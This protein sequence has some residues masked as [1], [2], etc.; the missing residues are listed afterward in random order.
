MK[1][2]SE[3][4]ERA[5]I[6]FSMYFGYKQNPMPLIDIGKKMNCSRTRAGILSKKAFRYLIHPKYRER[7]WEE[8]GYKPDEK[9]G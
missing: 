9:S 6:A 1:Q 8:Y 3:Y 7:I 2:L 5:A 4:H